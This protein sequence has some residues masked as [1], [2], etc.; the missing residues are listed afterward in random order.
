M[1]DNFNYNQAA[2]LY[3]SQSRFRSAHVGY[4]R[5]DSAAAAI[6]FAME[7]LPVEQLRGAA[8]EVEDE[9]FD[10]EGIASL[11]ASPAYPLPRRAPSPAGKA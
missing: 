6:R 2:E 8:L 7:E 11:Y 1:N 5:F 9:R 10:G 4:M 3:P